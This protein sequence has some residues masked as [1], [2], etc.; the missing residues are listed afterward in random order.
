MISD[1]PGIEYSQ[2]HVITY[3]TKTEGKMNISQVFVFKSNPGTSGK[4]E[5]N[6]EVNNWDYT[7]WAESTSP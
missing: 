2:K 1:I 5:D 3:K 6:V 4:T 7:P